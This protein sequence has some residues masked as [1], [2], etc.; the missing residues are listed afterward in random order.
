VKIY[1]SY[2]PSIALEETLNILGQ[3]QNSRKQ[4]SAAIATLMEAAEIGRSLGGKARGVLPA[5]YTYLGTARNNVM[6]CAGAEQSYR[7]SVETARALRGEDHEDVLQTKQRLGV[8]LFDTGRTEEGLTLLK[9]ALQ[10]AV[11]TK[12]AEDIFHTA[13][14]L[15][16]YGYR[17]LVYG[18]LEDG[19][20]DLSQYIDIRR[21]AKRSVTRVFADTL[22]F[23]ALAETEIGHYRD[24]ETD[25]NEAATIRTKIGDTLSSGLLYPT[26]FA[27][28]HLL[29]ATGKADTAADLLDVAPAETDDGGNLSKTWLAYGLSNAELKL[30]QNRHEDAIAFA[31]RARTRLEASKVRQYLK[32]YEFK[33]ALIEGKALLASG[34]AVEAKPLLERAVNLSYMIRDASQ[35]LEL[36]DAQIALGGCLLHLGEHNHAQGLGVQAQRIHSK[37]QEIGPHLRQSLRDL[38]IRIRRTI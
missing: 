8:F 11:R 32:H 14:V 24:A 19:L 5:I 2:P 34:H 18:R 30:A 33:A 10:L 28:A 16:A 25:L 12:G 21:R 9:E 6:D 20:T 37:H 36:A 38:E 7:L 29:V 17:L 27:R 31:R 3:A 13:Q 26:I 22:G 1:R 15:S 35:S 4:Y 23:R